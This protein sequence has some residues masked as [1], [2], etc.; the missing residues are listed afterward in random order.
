MLTARCAY[1]LTRATFVGVERVSRMG[2][3]QREAR[4]TLAQLQ[5]LQIDV[6]A[7]LFEALV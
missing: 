7:G 4:E 2:S 1:A 6:V 5:S 3:R